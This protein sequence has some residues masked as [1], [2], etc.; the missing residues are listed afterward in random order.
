MGVSPEQ[1]FVVVPRAAQNLC[2]APCQ[3]ERE[4]VKAGDLRPGDYVDIPES[5]ALNPFPVPYADARAEEEMGRVKS[6]ETNGSL[7]IVF[8]NLTPLTV[9]PAHELVIAARWGD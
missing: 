9:T 5:M 2:E 1:E 7:V 8:Y 6:L 4:T 3:G